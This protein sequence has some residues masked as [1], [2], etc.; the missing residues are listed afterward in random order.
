MIRL[1]LLV[2]VIVL[3][4]YTWRVLHLTSQSLWRDEVDAIYFALRNLSDTLSMFISSA[5]NGPLY[6]L[7]LRPWLLVTGTSEFALRYPS[8]MA[9]TASIPI[10]W[11]LARR[12]LPSVNH[13]G[14]M[15]LFLSRAGPLIAAL[16]LA[17]NPY[18]LWYSQEGKMYS[19]VVFLA[20][21][22]SFLLL[23]GVLEAEND[24][25]PGRRGWWLWAGYLV[26]VGMSLHIHLLMI[27]IVPL[28]VFWV[29]VIWPTS[30]DV[31]R[32]YMISLAGL[33]LPYLPMVW[34]QW[35]LLLSTSQR[36]GYAFT[37]LEQV[38]RTLLL[39]HT[40]GFVPPIELYWLAPIFFVGLVG[41]LMGYM[42][43]RSLPAGGGRPDEGK[44][45]EQASVRISGLIRYVIVLAW[46][47]LPIVFIH[48]ISLR[49]PVFVDRYI[50]WIGPAA[51]LVTVLGLAVI[52]QNAAFL[53]RPLVIAIVLYMSGL[54][55]YAGWQ[56]SVVDI[57]Y[58]LRSAIRQIDALREEDELLIL[59]IPH[60]EFS[61]RY[62]T[63]DQG[64]SPFDGSDTR[65][66]IWT[67]GLW[68]NHGKPDDE[69]QTE[70]ADQMAKVA[71]NHRKIW[72]LRSEVE[73]WDR[74]YLMDEWLDNNAI[75]L[76]QWDFH[77]SQVRYYEIK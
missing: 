18:Q 39:N 23:K 63:S 32:N 66:G 26:V 44:T 17:I 31:W 52:W 64:S 57:K 41:V 51:I 5:Q 56:Q 28:H 29:I 65:L 15:D 59:Q 33:I 40:Q 72:V 22:A 45:V 62:Y 36:T 76:Q 24:Q 75:R 74:R 6:F 14:E 1:R 10:F 27:L 12:L 8:A 70:V 58:D 4:A 77:G 21:L 16:F 7:S 38:L 47:V 11:Q 68:T 30:R 34:W 43:V 25:F 3:L 13:E 71:N 73:M 60:L 61:F 67:E 19:L 48:G 42:E 54:W 9:G 49:Q 50:I 53:A 69:S 55:L 2:T 35:D 20:L 37:P 46:L